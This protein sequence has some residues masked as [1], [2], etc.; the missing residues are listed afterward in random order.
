MNK[1]FANWPKLQQGLSDESQEIVAFTTTRLSG[2]SRPPF[3]DFNLGLH[4]GDDPQAVL[5][6]RTELLNNCALQDAQWLEQV[7]G[8]TC[9]KSARNS[10]VPVA[11]ACW[12]DETELACV[13]M[14]ADCLP[15]AFRQGD[16]IAVA[17]AGWRGLLNGVLEN[18]LC[19]LDAATTDIWLG[20]A[21]GAQVFEVGA[22]VREQFI[23]HD[24]NSEAAF[25]PSD[26][27]GKWLADIY[28]LAKLRLVAAGVASQH[29]YG[30]DYCTY[31]DHERFFSYRCN[32]ITGRMATVIY[33]RKV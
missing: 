19:V 26:N 11:D 2:N 21:I 9:I 18:T 6:N 5:D 33:R 29:I 22:E 1:V 24:A 17:H 8:I 27:S 16:K 15:V 31:T 14:T 20:P 12:S 25:I 13:V 23:D 10:L 3:D 30:G 28:Q 7:H 4:V 32:A